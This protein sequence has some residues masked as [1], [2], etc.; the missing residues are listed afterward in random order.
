MIFELHFLT[1]G[2]WGSH[3]TLQL[4]VFVIVPPFTIT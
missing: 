3:K 4:L 1:K 2:E